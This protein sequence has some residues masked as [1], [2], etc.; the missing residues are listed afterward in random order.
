[1]PICAIDSKGHTT[2]ENI[3]K[4][5]YWAIQHNATI[6]NLSLGKESED[7]CVKTA[8]NTA[9]KKNIYV[10]ASAGDYGNQFLLFPANI[11][12]VISVEAQNKSGDIYINSNY[13]DK[14][15]IAAPGTEIP[16]LSVDSNGKLFIKKDNGTS[17]ATAQISALVSLSLSI[18]NKISEKDLINAL[19]CSVDKTKFINAINLIK[20][21][22]SKINYNI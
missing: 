11:P 19:R 2:G 9:I 13:S 17:V 21:L 7:N 8:I 20:I 18:N 15:T 22:N 12:K 6:I 3:S 10:V 14:A 5:I 16:V 4:G 1:M